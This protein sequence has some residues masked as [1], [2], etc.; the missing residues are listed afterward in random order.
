MRHL[1]SM[2]PNHTIVAFP[3]TIGLAMIYDNIEDQITKRS[4]S[5]DDSM[6]DHAMNFGLAF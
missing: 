6:G 3:G 5:S 4:H 2:T 1:R